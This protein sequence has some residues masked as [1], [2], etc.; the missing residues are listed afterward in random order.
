MYNLTKAR[1]TSCACERHLCMLY[2]LLE[3]AI[4]LL[5]SLLVWVWQLNMDRRMS[6]VTACHCLCRRHWTKQI[7]QAAPRY[8]TMCRCLSWATLSQSQSHWLMTHLWQLQLGMPARFARPA[9]SN[10]DLGF[11]IKVS[12][13]RTFAQ[14][15]DGQALA[16]VWCRQPNFH[17]TCQ[18]DNVV[19]M[20]SEA[21]PATEFDLKAIT[22][23]SDY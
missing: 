23:I 16:C 13:W 15:A 10:A 22:Y 8:C 3:L 19:N 14:Q 21:C 17:T 2:D 9:S 7:K 1:V 5:D 11:V 4:S 20:I 12:P 6:A 18:Q